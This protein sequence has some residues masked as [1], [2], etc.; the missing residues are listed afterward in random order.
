MVS[1][2]HAPFHMV[3]ERHDEMADYMQKVGAQPSELAVERRNPRSVADK[4]AVG[5][6][7]TVW[8][9]IEE[10]ASKL[11]GGCAAQAPEWKV[12]DELIPEWLNFIKGFKDSEELPLN[13]YRETLLQNKIMRVIKKNQVKKYLEILAE[14]AELNAAYEKFYEQFGARLKLGINEDST[15]GVKIA[16]VLMFNT[17]KPGGKRIVMN[18]TTSRVTWTA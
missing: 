9:V 2:I 16:D 17:S 15:V 8:R 3:A 6:R 11:N 13:I 10:Q 18:R 12:C 14:I 7:R 4:N 5:G 1:S